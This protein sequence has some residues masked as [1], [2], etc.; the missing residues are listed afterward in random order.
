M[1]FFSKAVMLMSVMAAGISAMAFPVE[2]RIYPAVTRDDEKIFIY[3]NMISEI[4]FYF[5][6]S[7]KDPVSMKNISL[8]LELPEGLKPRSAIVIQ[9]W[10]GG[11]KVYEFTSSKSE[12]EGYVKYTNVP[13][14]DSTVSVSLDPEALVGYTGYYMVFFM[15]PDKKA[16]IPA[17]FSMTWK[18]KN[19]T[20]EISGAQPF[21]CLS[22]KPPTARLKKFQIWSNSGSHYMDE[23]E[24]A[25]QMK[26]L[27][28]CNAKFICLGFDK[29]KFAT[30]QEKMWLKNGF[31][32]YD[33][34][35]QRFIFS[36]EKPTV[37]KY[38]EEA[39][40]VNIKGNHVYKTNDYRNTPL[41]PSA[42]YNPESPVFKDVL[43]Y[44]KEKVSAGVTTFYS[45]H[46]VDIYSFCFCPV[47]LGQFAEQIKENPDTIKSMNPVDI[48]K[49]YPYEWYVFRAQ[50]SGKMAAALKKA[51]NNPNVRIGLNSVIVYTSFTYPKL[52]IG[53]S[54]FADDP[55]M[56][57]PYVDFHNLDTLFGSVR[58]AVSLDI[59]MRNLK[60]PV[61]DRTYSNYCFGWEF[62]HCSARHEKSKVTGIPTGSNN[63]SEMQRLSILN[64]AATGCAG[65]ELL[66]NSNKGN[67]DAKIIEAVASA[68]D[69]LAQY[70]KVWLEGKRVENEIKVF[71]LNKEKSPYFDDKSLISGQ[72]WAKYFFKEMG[73]LMYRAH[74]YNNDLVFSIF[75]WDVYQTQE[76]ALIP[77]KLQ[78]KKYYVYEKSKNIQWIPNDKNDFWT[79]DDLKKGIF[80]K[81]S[82]L[83]ETI[84]TISEKAPEKMSGKSVVVSVEIPVSQKPYNLYHYIN[85]DESQAK[86]GLDYAIEKALKAP[87]APHGKK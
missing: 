31:S 63:R 12:R 13:I 7:G 11:N 67:A 14:P 52:G 78:D 53:R 83:T 4:S 38:P 80:I 42:F 1:K 49:K 64:L 28:K 58:D 6:K 77:E 68:V 75:N 30:D 45:D 35:L 24:I 48:V 32:L 65:V 69:T 29:N 84:L 33:S 20:E 79:L 71:Y 19:K 16:K 37:P 18:L 15:E 41:C 47:C 44:V 72:I 61:I 43:N 26:L 39:Y 74:L 62:P 54:L 86:Y 10:K 46:E 2:M 25:N 40:H 5:F 21:E 34:D 23:A 27:E 51:L 55:R 57:D 73:P 60:K 66:M 36:H 9:G 3:D 59:G 22:F 17:S 81:T 50:Q 82:P 87:N 85:T 56:T 70:E 8:D 76:I